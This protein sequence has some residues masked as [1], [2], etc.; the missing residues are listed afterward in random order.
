[1]YGFCCC[2]C[3]CCQE[4]CSCC[5]ERNCR[6]GAMGGRTHL[7]LACA[8]TIPDQSSGWSSRRVH[9]PPPQSRLEAGGRAGR[10][11]GGWLDAQS[12]AQGMPCNA[13][14]DLTLSAVH[15]KSRTRSM[16]LPGLPPPPASMEEHQCVCAGQGKGQGVAFPYPAS[17]PPACPH[18]ARRCTVPP[19]PAEQKA[20]GVAE[21]PANQHSAGRELQ[22][23]GAVKVREQMHR[24]TAVAAH[25]IRG[26]AV[27]S[28]RWTQQTT[29]GTAAAPSFP[30]SRVQCPSPAAA[31]L[32]AATA[33]GVQG[34]RQPLA[35]SGGGRPQ[36]AQCLR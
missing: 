32:P 14:A 2:C 5:Q 17:T 35:G 8:A 13:Q 23:I 36:T 9:R 15:W 29:A 25:S 7:H 1:M 12:R 30:S 4:R 28:A 20:G 22:P 18:L 34:P 10:G 26:A 3:C 31:A 21:E 6:R 11:G 33:P 19:Q 16:T 27:A 24:E